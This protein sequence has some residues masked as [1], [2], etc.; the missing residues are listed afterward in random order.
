[1]MGRDKETTGSITDDFNDLN[2][3]YDNTAIHT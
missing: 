2:L 1:M 3:D